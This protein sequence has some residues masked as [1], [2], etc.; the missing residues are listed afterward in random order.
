[1]IRAL[2]G[3]TDTTVRQLAEHMHI[4][5]GQMSRR[6]KGKIP[7]RAHELVAIAEF[8]GVTVGTLFRDPL[9]SLRTRSDK[10]GTAGQRH[11]SVA[12]TTLRPR[13]GKYLGP[14]LLATT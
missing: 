1:M 8:F 13:P 14:P 2:L 6:M 3:A 12:A 9:E 11:L 10:S 5:E 4:N 7:W